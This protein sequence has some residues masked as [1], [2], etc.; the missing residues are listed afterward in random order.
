MAINR[1]SLLNVLFKGFSYPLAEMSSFFRINSIANTQ[2]SIDTKVWK[3]V[4][5]EEGFGLKQEIKLGE[6][7]SCVV[8][9]IGKPDLV[10][11]ENDRLTPVDH[12]TVDHVDG[13]TIHQYKPSTQMPGYVYACEELARQLGYS[14]RVDRCVINIC[15][16]TRPAENPRSGKP[17]PR[18]IRAYPNFSREELVEWKQRV[19]A[20]CERLATCIKTNTWN[21]AETQCHNVYR[22]DCDFVSLHSTTPSARDTI[23][24]A[25]FEQTTPWRPYTTKGDE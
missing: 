11:V 20:Q 14:V 16:R 24:R 22:R 2:Y 17:K 7:R 3:I 12:K 25:N 5:V 8:Y 15:A 13:N 9:W 4:G 10:V 19:I 6:T 1:I 23:L 18:F 21:W